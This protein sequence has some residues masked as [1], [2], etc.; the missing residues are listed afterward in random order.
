[1]AI[2]RD[3]SGTVMVGFVINKN[4]TVSN[5]VLD[6]ASVFKNSA[7]SALQRSVPFDTSGVKS[8]MPREYSV[9]IT[10]R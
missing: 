2:R 7:K 9:P 3:I 10:Y 6:G 8:M 1:M 5:V 4:G